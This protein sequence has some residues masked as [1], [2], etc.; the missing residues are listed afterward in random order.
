[1]L[2]LQF[3]NGESAESL[4]INGDEVIIIEGLENLKPKAALKVKIEKDGKSK[5]IECTLRIDTPNEL[6]YVKAGGILPYVLN[7]L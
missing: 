2:P 4:G 1:V 6:K 7:R 3:K 5:E